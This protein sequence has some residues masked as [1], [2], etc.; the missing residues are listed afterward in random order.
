MILFFN[1]LL[2]AFYFAQGISSPMTVDTWLALLLGLGLQERPDSR[3]C[4]A[5]K[6]LEGGDV[7]VGAGREK[8][9]PTAAALHRGK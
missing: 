7:G 6:L 4:T 5:E 1:I 2:V 8:P 3:A 9:R